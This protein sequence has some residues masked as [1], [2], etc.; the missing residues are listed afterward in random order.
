MIRLEIDEKKSLEKQFSEA[1]KEW[2]TVRK[3]GNDTKCWP[4]GMYMNLLR[5]KMMRI[6][7]MK[8]LEADIEDNSRW[9][10]PEKVDF[11]YNHR[12]FYRKDDKWKD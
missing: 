12:D 1:K 8:K 6:R 3:R 9:E 10:I 2:D 4:D 11:E 7:K 5:S